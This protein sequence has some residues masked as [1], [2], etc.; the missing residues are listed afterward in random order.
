MTSKQIS[1]IR[2]FSTWSFIYHHVKVNLISLPDNQ[3]KPQCASLGILIDET[4]T[5][6][7]IAADFFW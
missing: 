1:A 2:P 7:A 3:M 6:P 5:T 4:Q